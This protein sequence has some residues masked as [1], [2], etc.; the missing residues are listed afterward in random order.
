MASRDREPDKMN[1]RIKV[2]IFIILLP[3]AAAVVLSF[4]MIPLMFLAFRG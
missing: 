3:I 1:R 2:L 4:F